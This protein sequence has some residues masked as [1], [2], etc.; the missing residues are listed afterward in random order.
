MAKSFEASFEQINFAN[1]AVA[2]KTINGWVEAVTQ[3]KIK[4]LIPPGIAF[5]SYLIS[6]I[7]VRFKLTIK[8]KNVTRRHLQ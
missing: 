3:H 4:D 5:N 1:S 6:G 7:L 8:F 2:T